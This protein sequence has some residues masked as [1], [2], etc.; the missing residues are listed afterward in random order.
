MLTNDIQGR[1][2]RFSMVNALL[3]F[4]ENSLV[5]LAP[6]VCANHAKPSSMDMMIPLNIPRMEVSQ[7]L[8]L[9]RGMGRRAQVNFPLF[10]IRQR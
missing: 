6:Y 5:N 9:D 7:T 1:V 8:L 3:W 4:P 2:V 10:K